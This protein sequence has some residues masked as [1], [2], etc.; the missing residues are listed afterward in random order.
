VLASEKRGRASKKKKNASA[1][2]VFYIPA[3]DTGNE[4]K[5][6]GKTKKKGKKEREKEGMAIKVGLN[7]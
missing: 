1:G 4:R 7:T 2:P 6:G 3:N 5:E